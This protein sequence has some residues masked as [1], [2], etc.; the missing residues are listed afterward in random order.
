MDPQEWSSNLGTVIRQ[1]RKLAG[2]S[3]L[4]LAQL[5]GVGKTVVFDVEAG[6]ATVRMATLLRILAA[7]NIELVWRGP[8]AERDDA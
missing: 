4:E 2:L 5:A 6:K 7:L 1:H 8:L 3:Q